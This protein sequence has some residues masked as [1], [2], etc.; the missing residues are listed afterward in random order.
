MDASKII[1]TRKELKLKDIVKLC[2]EMKPG[3]VIGLS[4]THALVLVPL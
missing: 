4:V 2:G 3:D 1:K